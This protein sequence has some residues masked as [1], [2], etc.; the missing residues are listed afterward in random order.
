MRRPGLRR[1][2]QAVLALGA[3]AALGLLS[4]LPLHGCARSKYKPL[5]ADS[6]SAMSVDSLEV[7]ARDAQSQWD[8]GDT[9]GAAK[10]TA[11]IVLA[12]LR[13]HAEQ[14]PG[15]EWGGR[16]SALL[17]SLNF[18]AEVQSD[19]CV[20]V[21]NFFSRSDP[22]KGS[23]PWLF[24]CGPRTIDAQSIEGKGLKIVSVTARGLGATAGADSAPPGVAALFGR[25]AAAGYQPLLMTW[26]R[27]RDGHWTLDQ[28]LGSDSL[29]A[30]GGGDFD[31]S[32]S[33]I[34]LTARTY[35]PT[36][37][38]EE[39]PTCPHVYHEVRLVWRGAGFQ[40]LDERVLP[41]PYATFVRFAT[42]MATDDRNTAG[43]LV[44]D[45]HWVDEAE[46]LEFNA[47]HGSWR[48]APATDENAREMV[49]LRGKQEA[50]RVTFTPR[51]GDWLID[52]IA[53]TSTSIE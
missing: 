3:L 35:R 10:L 42:A 5:P 6:T 22:E 45:A 23:W 43:Q 30:F 34:V 37:R 44:S 26:K 1:G 32:D 40:R 41:S 50:Y 7:A 19:P 12:D 48:V 18:G 17:D 13:A 8:G 25:R 39:C 2:T 29:G 4:S 27:A 31:R 38:F 14:T 53:T 33:G 16:T 20:M 9:E 21:V 15:L 46:R 47:Q 11:R 49:F 52:G 51:S 28:T 24:Y 36:A